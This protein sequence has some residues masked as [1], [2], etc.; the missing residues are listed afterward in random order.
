MKIFIKNTLSWTIGA[1]LLFLI[2]LCGNLLADRSTPDSGSFI[3][4]R[5]TRGTLEKTISCTGTL[6]AV[7]TV[8][9]GTQ[10]SGTIK[11]VRVDYNQKVR[12]GQVL[13]RLD[14]ALFEA[15][16][17]EAEADLKKGEEELGLARTKD[18]CNRSLY[19]KGYIS[20]L[21]YLPIRTAVKTTEA[22]VTSAEATLRKARTNLD[23]ATIRSPIDGTVIERK[24]DAG[25]TIAANFS[26]PT[27]FVIAEDL[28]RMQIKTNV[29]ESDIGLVREK[30]PVRFTVQTY[31]KKTFVGEVT[32]IRL[33]PKTISNVVHY[34]VVVD[35]ENEGGLLLPGMTAT[36]DL[37]IGRVDNALLV[38]NS[39]LRF[40]PEPTEGSDKLVPGHQLSTAA[41]FSM[42]SSLYILNENGKP[43]RVTVQTGLSNDQMTEVKNTVI[44]QEDTMVISG[45]NRGKEQK[46][47]MRSLLPAPPDN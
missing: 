32:Q 13:A 2:V 21:D 5:I 46:K 30:I 45:E 14:P 12:K 25:Q 44:I 9:V 22:T 34:T 40:S 36:A 17:T 19:T 27:L 29:D 26:T 20:E 18:S 10:V 8:E 23:Y 38:P 31:Q 16:V 33:Q 1:G 7:G 37:I 24:I 6:E 43:S 47:T 15:A 28:S 39:A 42:S 4:T 41:S 11:E 3:L 35:A